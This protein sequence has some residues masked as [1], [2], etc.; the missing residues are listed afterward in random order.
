[1]KTRPLGKTGLNTSLIGMG[2][3]HLVETAQDEVNFL[4][5]SY[6]DVGGNYIETA[7]DY[8]DGLSEKKIGIAVSH[9]RKEYILAS[10]CFQRSA[11]A[12]EKSIDRSLK[13]L[14]TD[15][16]DILFLH[17]VQKKSEVEKI[18]LP[19]GAMEAV[20]RARKQGKIRFIAISGHGQP[21]ALMLAINQYPFDVLMTGFNYFDRFNFPAT[22]NELLIECQLHQIGLIGMKALAD[23]FLYRSVEPAVRYALSL[24]ISTLVLGINRKDYLKTDL[25]IIDRFQ[26]M[27][28]KDKE[29]LFDN[30]PELG[31]YVCRLCNKCDDID[32]INPTEI[33]LIEGEFDRQMSDGNV[34]EPAD[35]ALIERLKHWFDQ[36]DQAI[37]KY[38]R[39]K[40]Q[41]DINKNYRYLNKKCPYHIDIDRKL[42][43]VHSKLTQNGYIF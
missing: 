9:R 2:G 10:K 23:G 24:P 1:M 20:H 26:P 42:K 21:D 37:K 34:P 35:F 16:L 18:L 43:L 36:K 13:N 7:A 6:L 31:S 4:L 29:A 5:N 28:E 33:F 3:F 30:A 32:S 14:Q 17:G 27:R 25:E 8:G 41:V 15:H 39:L 19:G 11:D 22:E 12:A 38:Q 40:E